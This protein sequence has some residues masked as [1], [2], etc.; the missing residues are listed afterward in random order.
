MTKQTN[1]AAHCAA[2]IHHL[3]LRFEDSLAKRVQQG[4]WDNFGTEE[5]LRAQAEQFRRDIAIAQN[6]AHTAP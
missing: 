6:L 1:I 4:L 3:N 2:A 5:R